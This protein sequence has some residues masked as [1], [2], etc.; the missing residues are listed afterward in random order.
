MVRPVHPETIVPEGAPGATTGHDGVHEDLS[1]WWNNYTIYEI[2]PDGTQADIAQALIDAHAAGYGTV[3]LMG[4]A[5]TATGAAG[6]AAFDITLPTVNLDLGGATITYTGSGI[7]LRKRMDPMTN[8]K[9][10]FVVNGTIDGTGA[11]AGA[12][13]IESGNVVGASWDG[14]VV[15]NFTGAGSVGWD[16]RNSA[17]PTVGWMERCRFVVDSRNNKICYR[18]RADSGQSS[19]LYNDFA[20]MRFNVDAGQTAFQTVSPSQVFDC[21]LNLRGNV[22]N[23]GTI[24]DLAGD[25]VVRPRCH[26][27]IEQTNGTGAVLFASGSA[28][29]AYPSGT[30]Q[31]NNFPSYDAGLV[32]VDYEDRGVDAVFDPKI[33]S[34]PQEPLHAMGLT[35]ASGSLGAFVSVYDGGV[36]ADFALVK[37]PFGGS[38]ADG[39]VAAQLDSVTRAEIGFRPGVFTSGSRPAA[40]SVP[41][42]TMIYISDLD[43]PVWSTGVDWRDGTGAVA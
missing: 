27:T 33:V 36:G 23:A 10:G 41:E 39:R 40:N 29:F 3:R 34:S 25:S 5:Y 19:Y 16:F 18:F 20:D 11:A 6:T 31:V 2:G 24:F 30:F 32:F 26:I 7:C 43:K 8:A 35:V 17:A 1:A 13:G 4:T 42:G 12:V 38:F 15:Q 37:I 14:V 22:D 9:A 28:Q 21:Q